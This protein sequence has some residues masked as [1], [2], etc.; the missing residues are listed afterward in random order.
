MEGTGLLL[1]PR[2]VGEKNA[3]MGVVSSHNPMR[4]QL[5]PEKVRRYLQYIYHIS[6]YICR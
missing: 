1:V 4:V 2:A 5:G 3:A 6:V